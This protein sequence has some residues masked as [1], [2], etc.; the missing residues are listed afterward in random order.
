MTRKACREGHFDCIGVNSKDDRCALDPSRC[1]PT[2]SYRTGRRTEL[3][4]HDYAG[5]YECMR[6]GKPYGQ[7][8]AAAAYGWG[9]QS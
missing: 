2:I 4:R 8:G 3:W 1:G 7:G 6:C 9:R 5:G